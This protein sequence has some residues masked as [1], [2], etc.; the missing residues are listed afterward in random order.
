MKISDGTVVRLRVFK[1][2]QFTVTHVFPPVSHTSAKVVQFKAP[3]WSFSK[4]PT[5]FAFSLC[6]RMVAFRWVYWDRDYMHTL[7][8]TAR[9]NTERCCWK[10]CT[11]SP[12]HLQHMCHCTV[13]IMNVTHSE[14]SAVFR[15][16]ELTCINCYLKVLTWVNFKKKKNHSTPAARLC[17]MCDV[18]Q[19]QMQTRDFSERAA[20][21]LIGGWSSVVHVV[22]AVSAFCLN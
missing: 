21:E 19:I 11:F 10:C 16:F 22:A 20:F 3:S 9:W 13:E 18:M 2:A 1:I 4:L 12:I 6:D 14:G 7:Q 17:L 15:W 8:Y 5:S